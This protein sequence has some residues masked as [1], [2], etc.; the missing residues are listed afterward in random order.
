M[1]NSDLHDTFSIGTDAPRIAFCVLKRYLSSGPPDI[2]HYYRR[3]RAE[4]GK[5]ISRQGDIH[6]NLSI[7][8]R[9][10]TAI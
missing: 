9:V 4:K 10:I 5:Y 8:Q 1:A 3:H 2:H 6:D 7:D